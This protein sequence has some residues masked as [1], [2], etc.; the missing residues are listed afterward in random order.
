M[1]TTRPQE[2]RT[3]PGCTLDANGTE[4][5]QGLTNAVVFDA[6]GTL[7][8]YAS[9]RIN[10]YRHLFGAGAARLPLLTQEAGIE[11]FAEDLGLAH[12]IPMMRR[13]LAQEIASLRLFDDVETTLRG[14][15]A[16]G[17]KIAICSNLAAEYG[18]FVRRLLPMA[19][20][21]I[22]SYE[23]GIKKPDP[24]IYE[25][26]CSRVSCKPRDVLFIGDSKRADFDGPRSFGMQAR[27][28]DRKAG[29]TLGAV[30]SM[31]E[32]EPH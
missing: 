6:F 27:L 18:P 1:D 2:N 29:Q 31:I 11:T 30:L 24:A 7:I 21:Y 8:T 15:R 22:F 10:P 5:S 14:L 19:E 16:Q 20:A 32:G 26:V 17:R 13:E 28:I 12:L 3:R 25:A 4:R 23:L 9:H